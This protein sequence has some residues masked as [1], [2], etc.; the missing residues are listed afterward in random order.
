MVSPRRK[1]T[2]RLM[3][4]LA[5][6]LVLYVL[7]I[8]PVAVITEK[9][10]IPRK[11]AAALHFAYVPVLFMSSKVPAFKAALHVYIK[12]WAHLLDRL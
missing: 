1:S 11:V 9:K 10:P 4:H 5:A 12:W 8:G 3:A 7:S 2:L 6:V